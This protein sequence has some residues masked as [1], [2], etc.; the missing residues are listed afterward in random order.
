MPAKDQLLEKLSSPHGRKVLKYALVSVITVLVTQ[1]MLAFAFG[2]MNW[3]ARPSNVL[4]SSVAA[5]PAYFLNRMWTWGKR[6]RSHL[7]KEV[8]PF[9]ALVFIGLVFSTW[10]V[11]LAEDVAQD[12]TESHPLRTLIVMGGQFVAYGLLWVVKFMIFN[13]LM[14]VHRHHD[15]EDAPAIDGKAGVPS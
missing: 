5:V 1:I 7:M 12:A 6:G 3:A 13:R 14:F 8:V 11:G 9:W 2:V 15:L 4:A 10:A